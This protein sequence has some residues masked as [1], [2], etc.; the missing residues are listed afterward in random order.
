VARFG[1]GVTAEESVAAPRDVL[2]TPRESECFLLATLLVLNEDREALQVIF[3]TDTSA[4][5]LPTTHDVLW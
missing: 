4:V 2:A 1:L 3:V 5:D